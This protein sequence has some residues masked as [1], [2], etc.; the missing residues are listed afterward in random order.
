MQSMRALT[1][2]AAALV[3]A[4]CGGNVKSHG[5]TDIDGTDVP[6]THE[7]ST[8]D[9]EPDT[10][11]DTGDDVP[12]V[13]VDPVPDGMEDEDSDSDTILDVHEG[14][15]DSGGPADTDGDTTPDYED[16]D[17]DGDGI[18]DADEAGDTDPDTAPEDCD[19]DGEANFRDLD[20]DGDWLSDEDEA[21][22]GTDPCNPDSDGDGY[23]DLMEEA[24][25]S[26]P[27]DDTDSP[28]VEGDFVY[29]MPYN[30]TPEPALDT[31]VFST[32]LKQAEVFFLVDTTGSMGTEIASL[33]TEL[34]TVIIPGI[35]AIIEDARYGVG[36]FDDYP[37]NPYGST[38][39]LVFQLVQRMTTDTAAAQTAVNGLTT[40][41]GGDLPESQVPAL[42]AISTGSGLGTYLAAATGCGTDETGYPCFRTSAVAIIVMITDA[43]FHNGPGDTDM[44]ATTITPTPPTYTEAVT[45]LLAVN[46]KVVTIYSNT[47]PG[48]QV[49]AEQLATDTGAVDTAGDPLVYVTTGSGFGTQVIDAVDTLATALPIRVDAIAEDDPSDFLDAVET[50]IDEVHTNTTGASIWDPILGEM[51]TCT[52]GLTVATP[53]TPPTVD[54]FTSVAPGVSVCFDIVPL[55]NTT[56]APTSVPLVF[57]ATISVIGDEFTPLDAR[58]IYFI[59]PP[60]I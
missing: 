20:S 28:S 58:D 41:Y 39:D 3:L 8:P 43:P 33:R 32:S 44:Y 2:L 25:G 21:S 24:Y 49:D 15:W 42:W 45:A 14:R 47:D 13:P 23:T 52:S 10:A 55:E 7:D 5:D 11:P 17:S 60:T 9:V 48:G 46:A 53:G 54:Y 19:S 31:L 1:L 30:D 29:V 4:S 16:T 37:V 36:R 50:F 40:H 18:L 12:D 38:G 35:D 59:V 6:D 56:V 27:L 34:S 57:R 51:R 22:A 26:D